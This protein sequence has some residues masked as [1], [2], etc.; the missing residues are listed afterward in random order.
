[1]SK[2]PAVPE[3]LDAR[4]FGRPIGV[5]KEK[6]IINGYVVA[7]LGYFKT[8]GRGQFTA[9]SLAKIVSLY[10]EKPNGIKVRSSHPNMSSD[11][12]ATTIG[13]SKDAW[14]DGTRVRANMYLSAH[15]FG[16]E[17]DYKGDKVLRMAEEDPDLFG[18]SLVL[19]TEQIPVLDDLK[20]PKTDKDGNPIPPVWMPVTLHASDVVG[21]GDAV[22]GSFL[23][24]EDALELPDGAA[25][26]AT[27]AL[28]QFFPGAS[29]EVVQLRVVAFLDRYLSQRYGPQ[30]PPAVPP[31]SDLADVMRRRLR[32]KE[33][34]G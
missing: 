5:D 12:L 22:H 2:M 14:L 24:V 16:P 26:M 8:P 3:W 23:S 1:M 6:R 34:A 27:Q 32:L 31:A 9:E 20:R 4:S 28:D 33:K 11:G 29:R 13:R 7:E 10:Q 17:G 21:D 25:R 18:S 19:K 30:A 15:A